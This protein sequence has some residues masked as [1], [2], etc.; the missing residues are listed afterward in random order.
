MKIKHFALV[1]L[2]AL[3][4]LLVDQAVASFSMTDPANIRADV[5][6][7]L[8]RQ[9]AELNAF[10]LEAMGL[11]EA[12]TPVQPWTGSYWP[13]SLGGIA[14]RYN[15]R[16][17]PTVGSWIELIT[18]YESNHK[19]WR[20]A[21]GK[22][23]S[24]WRAMYNHELAQKLSPSEKYDLAMGDVSFALTRKIYQEIDYRYE[25]KQNRESGLWK[26]NPGLAS[27]SGICDGWTTAALHLPRP[28]KKVEVLSPLGK[29]I[30]FYPDDLKALASQLFARTNRWLNI[31][32]V[33]NRCRDRRPKMDYSGR[34]IKD[35]CRDIDAGLWHTTVMNRIGIDQ[36]GFV[37]D[38]DNKTSVNNHPV[39]GYQ[40]SYFNP[41]TGAW[42]PL[43]N[44][45]VALAGVKDGKQALRHPRATKLVGV[46]MNLD[47]LDYNWPTGKPTDSP[48]DDSQKRRIYYA[49]DLE[50]D[51]Q[52]EILGGQF[53]SGNE[54]AETQ[55]DMIWMLPKYQLAWS[56]SSMRADEGPTI[57]RNQ[58]EIWGNIAWKYNARRGVVPKDWFDAHL[59]SAEF[60]YPS[61]EPWSMIDSAA[62]LAEMVYY[63]FDQAR[64]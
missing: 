59:Q 35:E 6:R 33:G 12:R 46:G 48:A 54:H 13:D 49:Y 7:L 24:N 38:V 51:D 36:R 62:P 50:M 32:R 55:P 4:F 11:N 20:E 30:T 10:T 2:A 22:I 25:Y 1:F 26:R 43:E 19:D 39:Y 53:R 8:H 42:G 58:I 41:L 61:A 18:P 28:V 47:V 57:D 3:W 37:I 14:N 15:N 34:P 64:I 29:V 27:W 23:A 60:H 63:L 9:Y 21:H 45:V 56:R 16:T 5:E 44:S 52:G 17:F 31:E 40:V